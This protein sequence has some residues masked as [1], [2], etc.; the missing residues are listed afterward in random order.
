[1][2]NSILISCT[3]CLNPFFLES[4]C[5]QI[6]KFPHWIW[7]VKIKGS[8]LTIIHTTQLSYN[9]LMVQ[10][11]ED[12]KLEN[13]HYEGMLNT[14]EL[15]VVQLALQPQ[16]HQHPWQHHL[17]IQSQDSWLSAGGQQP[18]LERLDHLGRHNLLFNPIIYLC[19][20]IK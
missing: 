9:N 10:P 2:K 4:I 14:L 11:K 5:L 17:Q 12:E 6:S 18:L 8:R 19:N 13:Y 16:Q 15:E 7:R 3:K 1:M 20:Q